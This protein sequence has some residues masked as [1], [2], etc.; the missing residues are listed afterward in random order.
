MAIIKITE[1]VVVV[2]TTHLTKTHLGQMEHLVLVKRLDIFQERTHFGQIH[3]IERLLLILL[4]F[5][6]LLQY[7]V[8][9]LHV[10]QPV[11]E[12]VG[13]SVLNQ[14]Q[15]SVGRGNVESVRG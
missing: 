9:F 4:E 5:G 8:P 15:V 7:H 10:E 14:G 1:V 12:V 2:N 6:E 11:A 13:V 3:Q